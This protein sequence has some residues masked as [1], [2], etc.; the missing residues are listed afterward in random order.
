MRKLSQSLSSRQ[1]LPVKQFLQPAFAKI[2]SANTRLPR[3]QIFK[4]HAQLYAR[5]Y[6]FTLVLPAFPEQFQQ[7][8]N[9]NMISEKIKAP[10]E[11][12]SET[13]LQAFHFATQN[14]IT[15]S[16]LNAFFVF[17]SQVWLLS[18]SHCLFHSFT[19]QITTCRHLLGP[20]TPPPPGCSTPRPPAG[21]G[22]RTAWRA[23]EESLSTP[24]RLRPATQTRD[25][26]ISSHT[27]KALPR[28]NAAAC[29]KILRQNHAVFHSN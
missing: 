23:P 17:Y 9:C 1:P 14:K 5:F 19:Q 16:P 8:F 2:C 12:K 3:A 7:Y 28:P 22:T 18:F 13:N 26:F 24:T 15:P 11:T 21:R 29:V 10:N 4:P 27:A 6:R 20:L 25:C